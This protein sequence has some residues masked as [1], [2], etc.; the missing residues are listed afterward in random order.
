[1]SDSSNPD[2]AGAPAPDDRLDSTLDRID[3]LVSALVDDLITDNEQRELESLLEG[4]ADARAR[5]VQ[6]VQLHVDL[7][8]HFRPEGENPE[9]KSPVLGFLGPEDSGY[10]VGPQAPSDP[11]E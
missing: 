11:A 8:D 4:S 1:M 7:M 5:Y 6:G 10:I 3:Q 2:Q 9:P